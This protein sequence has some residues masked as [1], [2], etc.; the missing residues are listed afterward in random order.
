[1]SVVVS[2]AEHGVEY[3]G[4]L[5]VATGLAEAQRRVIGLGRGDAVVHQYDLLHGVSLRSGERWSWIL[6]YRDS[7]VCD[8]HGYEWPQTCARGG[9]PIC[10]LHMAN[11]VGQVPGISEADVSALTLSYTLGAARGGIS[12]A[13]YKLGRAYMKKLP[14]SLPHDVHAAARWFRRAVSASGEPSAAYSLAQMVLEGAIDG[15]HLEWTGGAAAAAS[16]TT[17]VGGINLAEAVRL[18]EV[19]AMGGHS[20]AMFNLG[21]AH[22]YGFGT[23]RR[24]AEVAAEWFEASGLPEGFV[25]VAMHRES[26]GKREEAA[27][28]GKRARSAGFGQPWRR[29]ARLLTGVGTAGNVDL[30]SRWPTLTALD[31]PPRL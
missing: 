14:S 7:E 20:F 6:W 27:Y 30:H 13:M 9:N 22:L 31:A 26:R 15:G 16:N 2:L 25:Y 12:G 17:V 28:W 23:P 24:S 21:V 10:Q 4:G 11:K 3:E 5:Y 29:K 19:A 8:E 1:V 18:F